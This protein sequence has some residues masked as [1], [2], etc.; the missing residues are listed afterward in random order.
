MGGVSHFWVHSGLAHVA[1]VSA[2]AMHDQALT[3]YRAVLGNHH[4][5]TLS[6]IDN[7]GET[8]RA[9]EPLLHARRA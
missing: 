4:P 7:L 6:S 3:V 9:L 5:D 1:L 2:R 8:L